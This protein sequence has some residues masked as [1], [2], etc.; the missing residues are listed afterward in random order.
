MWVVLGG[1]HLTRESAVRSS[2]LLW[3]L[4]AK[5]TPARKGLFCRAHDVSH[6]GAHM[7]FALGIDRLFCRHGALIHP[8]T[9]R[10]R[11]D[12]LPRAILLTQFDHSRAQM[13]VY[14]SEVDMGPSRNQYG[15]ER[16]PKVIPPQTRR[17]RSE[18]R[19]EFEPSVR[20]LVC[21]QNYRHASSNYLLQK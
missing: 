9:S 5:H 1:A 16:S 7:P 2:P 15:P 6:A 21:P 4:W 17:C 3:V 10:A 12:S 13:V 19:G 20:P 11:S 18:V 8:S 14:P